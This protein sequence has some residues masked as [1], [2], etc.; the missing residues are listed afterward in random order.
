MKKS[1]LLICLLAATFSAKAQVP[2]ESEFSRYLFTYFTRTGDLQEYL[3]FG[4]SRDA[5]NWRALNNNKPVL[6]SDTIAYSH[7]I[8]D[9]FLL[10]GQNGEFLIVCTDMNSER[11]GWGSN[12]GIV[13]LRSEDLVHWTHSYV[14]L[15]AQYHNFSDARFVWAP[16]VIYDENEGRYMVYF[17]LQRNYES[18]PKYNTYYAY[19][20]DDFTDFISEP[21]LL[22]AAK[23]YSIDNDIIKGPDGKWHLFYKGATFDSNGNEKQHGILRAVS[24]NLTG[25]YKEDFVFLDAYANTSTAVE[26]SSTFKLIGQQKYI[27]MYDVYQEGR[28]EFQTSTDLWNW[29]KEPQSF[30]KDFMPCHGSVIPI[31]LEEAKRLVEAFPSIDVDSILVDEGTWQEPEDT[32]GSLLV[33]YSFDQNADDSGKYTASPK[34][35]AQFIVLE[36]NNRVLFTGNEDGY[37]SLGPLMGPAVFKKLNRNYTISLDICVGKNNNSLNNHCWAW[38][39]GNGKTSIYS[40]L[41]NKGGNNNWYYEINQNKAYQTNSSRGL[42]TGEWHNVTVVQ[43]NNYNSIFIDGERCAMTNIDIKPSN[44]ANSTKQSWL[45]RSP[46]ESDS[47]MTNTMMDNLRIYSKALTQAQVK[48]LYESRPKTTAVATSIN[49]ITNENKP[50]NNNIY[51]L[52]GQRLNSPQRGINII[53]NHKILITQ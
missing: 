22:F 14:H 41:I 34:G 40:A 1:F 44:F 6:A 5:V 27:L 49:S 4:L 35:S 37:L 16:E 48:E 13:M 2:D 8:R 39:F 19:A 50:E 11:D 42:S 23:Y 15:P 51:S 25:P 43:K 7:G 31:T 53:N 9:P 21:K 28:F 29:T 36:D 33:S 46:Y 30:T 17:T 3:R 12:P 52:S 38:S 26:G 24:D 20:N 45:G 10:R 47:F 32:G 18:G